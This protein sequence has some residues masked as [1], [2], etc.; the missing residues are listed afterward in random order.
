[1]KKMFITVS[2]IVLFACCF[3]NAKATDFVMEA[4]SI[5]TSQLET[6][7]F[8]QFTPTEQSKKV[9]LIIYL[10]G[11]SGKSDDISKVRSYLFPTMFED[12]TLSDI[13]AYA[14]CPQVPSNKDGWDQVSA[15]VF[16]LIDYMC[17]NYNIDEIKISLIGHSMGG[18][19]TWS[20]AVSHPERFS[21]IVPMSGSIDNIDRNKKALGIMPIRAFVGSADTIVAPETSTEFVASLR[22]T[23]A[24]CEMTVFE[25]AT[26]FDIPDL[27]LKNDEIDIINWM[28][29][30]EQTN[31]ILTYGNGRVGIKIACPGR[32]TLILSHYTS[33][34]LQDVSLQEYDFEYGRTSKI[35][36][37]SLSAG[38]KIFLWDSFN[39]MN[40]VAKSFAVK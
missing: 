14:I 25:G 31:S 18:T 8:L 9:P 3:I 33:G 1:M 35:A 16:E 27:V 10:H 40:P 6:F 19:G 39:G 11:G 17:E 5:S 32:Y 4:K 21:C 23:N 24:D 20:L 26:H 29:S 38:D 15:S 13:E 7:R 37:I 36:P 30:Q 34:K 22:E 12:G 2:V 28:L